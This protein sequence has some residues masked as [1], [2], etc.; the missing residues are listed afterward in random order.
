MTDARDILARE[1]C[2][3][4]KACAL[5]YRIADERIAALSAA[6]LKIVGREATKE[7]WVA[8]DKVEQESEIIWRAMWDAA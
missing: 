8:G 1:E 3:R 4:E 7:M 5:C 2:G 6:G